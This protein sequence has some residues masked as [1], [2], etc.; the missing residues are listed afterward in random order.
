M[1]RTNTSKKK[2]HTTRQLSLMLKFQLCYFVAC[3][4]FLPTSFRF[5]SFLT[6]Y[7]LSFSKIL[8]LQHVLPLHFLQVQKKTRQI[9][10][11]EYAT[12]VNPFAVGV[13]LKT[14]Y[15]R[16]KRVTIVL[17]TFFKWYGP[18]S[19]Y[20]LQRPVVIIF[21]NQSWLSW[22]PKIHSSQITDLNEVILFNP[23]R[24]RLLRP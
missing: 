21:F 16:D 18:V 4:K 22:S 10:F 3:T 19:N 12:R 2:S 9:L 24:I 23:K 15:Q 7:L 14:N 11:E 1:N 13:K 17:V 20:F 8:L 5:L 6:Q